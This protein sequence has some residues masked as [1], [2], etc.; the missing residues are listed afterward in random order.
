VHQ[1]VRV[2]LGLYRRLADR[3]DLMVA[4]EIESRVS[5]SVLR[6]AELGCLGRWQKDAEVGKGA[7]AVVIAGEWVQNLTRLE[8]D[9]EERVSAAAEAAQKPWW[10]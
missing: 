7:V 2:L 4:P 10:R 6:Q 5:L 3:L 1:Q 9:L 8:A